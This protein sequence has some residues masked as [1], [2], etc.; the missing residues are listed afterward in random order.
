MSKPPPMGHNGGFTF[1]SRADIP[2]DVPRL[3]YFKCGI[4]DVLDDVLRMPKEERGVYLTALLVMYKEMEGLPADDKMAAMSLGLDVREWRH[5]KPKLIARGVLYE[6]SSGRIS[7]KRFEAEIS[8]YVTEFN[9]RREAAMEREQR[10]RAA[11]QIAPTSRRHRADIADR[12]P[13]HRVDLPAMS[14]TLPV[15]I[16]DDFSKKHNQNNETSSTSRPQ[17]EHEASSR[18]HNL[19]IRNHESVSKTPPPNASA[20]SLGIEA[21]PGD[22]EGSLPPGMSTAIRLIAVLF[23]SDTDPDHDRGYALAME[24][25][26][27]YDI[28]DVIEGAEDFISRRRD[29]TEYGGV[30]ERRFAEY[31]RQA[32]SNRK[33]RET[34]IQPIEKPAPRRIQPGPLGEGIELAANG[35]IILSNG[36]RSEWLE[37]FGGNEKLLDLTL[38]GAGTK[39]RPNAMMEPVGQVRSFLAA[40]CKNLVARK[41]NA[42]ATAEHTAKLRNEAA[43]QTGLTE[44][45]HDWIERIAAEAEASLKGGL[46]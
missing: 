18:A 29:R 1:D 21:S 7:N 24:Y 45:R 14:A 26:G 22:A 44:S 16:G 20:G 13:G 17:H 12:S 43:A 19:V 15:G 10:K 31:V 39:L 35:D 41:E 46:K 34:G 4:Q 23:G 25:G 8:V 28:E 40:A 6:R 38:T 2:K 33:R 11:G 30:N 3:Y 27:R 32:R 5:I 9:N 42:I 36:V 37:L